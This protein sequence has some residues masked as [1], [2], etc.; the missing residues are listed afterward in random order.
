MVWYEAL[1]TPI[2]NYAVAILTGQASQGIFR[3]KWILELGISH[4][5]LPQKNEAEQV[6]L[7][8]N[9]K[10]SRNSELHSTELHFNFFSRLVFEYSES[11]LEMC[12]TDKTVETFNGFSA[13]LFGYALVCLQVFVIN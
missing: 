11:T 4:Q 8:F 2:P 5:H 6:A 10:N 1:A 7:V 3:I 9:I 12:N 13:L